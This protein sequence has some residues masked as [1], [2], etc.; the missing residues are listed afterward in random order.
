MKKFTCRPILLETSQQ[1][2]DV[3]EGGEIK[4]RRVSGKYAGDVAVEIA[5]TVGRMIPAKQ[6]YE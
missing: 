2:I 5:H 3:D 6:L 1:V 4:G